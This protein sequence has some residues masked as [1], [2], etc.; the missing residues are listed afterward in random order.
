[1][2]V[3]QGEGQG[4]SIQSD[5]GALIAK[6]I[7]IFP[8]LINDIEITTILDDLDQSGNNLKPAYPPLASKLGE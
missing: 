4:E 2:L 5:K 6:L 3:S 8:F 7:S 1:M